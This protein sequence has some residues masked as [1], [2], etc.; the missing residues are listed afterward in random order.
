MISGRFERKMKAL[1]PLFCR[2]NHSGGIKYHGERK[3]GKC[4]VQERF[5]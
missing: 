5:P 1:E 4:R 2:V 3:P